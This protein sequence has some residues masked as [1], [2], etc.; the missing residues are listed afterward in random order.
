[1]RVSKDMSETDQVLDARVRP[2]RGSRP[3]QEEVSSRLEEDDEEEHE[4]ERPDRE[5]EDEADDDF[6]SSLGRVGGWLRFFY[7][8]SMGGF[9]PCF[10]STV[11]EA[12]RGCSRA[13]DVVREEE[14][15]E[16]RGGTIR[17]PAAE[18]QSTIPVTGRK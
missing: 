15:D 17:A 8:I 10:S 12:W 9:V 18:S 1:M 16:V 5:R 13:G 14:D 4:P 2:G 11:S 6:G 7:G 3:R